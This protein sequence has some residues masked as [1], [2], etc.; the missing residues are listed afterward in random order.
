MDEFPTLEEALNIAQSTNELNEETYIEENKESNENSIFNELPISFANTVKLSEIDNK[1]KLIP[2]AMDEGR[3][4]VILEDDMVIEGRIRAIASSLGRPLIRD[5]TTFKMCHDGTGRVGYARVL[6]EFNAVKLETSYLSSWQV[7]GHVD[8]RCSKQNNGVHVVGNKEQGNMDNGPFINDFNTAKES[9]K[10][11]VKTNKNREKRDSQ[12]NNGIMNKGHNKA[13]VRPSDTPVC[14]LC[15]CEE[16]GNILSYGTC[17]NCNSGTGNSFTYDTI[18][19]SFAEI[20]VIP[21]PPPQGHFNIY[22]CQIC[23]SNSHYGYECSQR[24]PLV[25]EPEPC[26]IQNFSENDYSHDLPGVN[27]LIDHH[28]CYKCGNSL[29][30]FFCHHCACEFCGNDAHVGYNC[31]AQIT[32]AQNKLM[33][34]LTSMCAMVGQLIQ[35]KQE[36]KQIEEEQAANDR[37]WKI[38][39]CCDDDD[40]YNSAITPN[41]PVDSLSMGDEHLNNIPATKS[42]KFIKSSVENLVPN[43]SESEGKNGCDVPACFTTFLN[44]LFDADYEFDSSDDQLLYDEDVSEK[45][46]SNPLFDEE[47]ISM[48]IY[49]HHF[50]VESDLIES[51]LNRDSSI[52]SSSKIDSL[53][54]EFAGELILLKSIPP[55]IDETDCDPEEDIRLIERLLYDNS[56]PRPPEEFVSENSNVDIESFSPSSI[57][58]EDSDSF[59]EEI[60]LTFTPDDPMLPGI[61]EDDDSERDIL[62]C[63]EL[64][65]N[66]SLS[67]PVIESYHFDILSFSHPPT[68]PPDGNTEILNIKMMGDNSEQ[69]VHMPRLMI[70]LVPNQEQSPDL[71]SHRRLEFFSFLLNALM[72]IHGKNIP[73]LDVPL[74]H[75]Y[76]LD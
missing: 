41:E 53:L 31:P 70:T 50:N 68:K 46:F 30:D 38:P 66:Y 6:A 37:Y 61:E 21:N 65:S 23:E 14:Y 39:A 10:N 24:V 60:D 56:S 3:E 69:K 32:I 55:R 42:D 19:E 47:I 9:N 43:P 4:V 74:F 44:I 71:L 5:K 76:P 28:R 13:K 72:M 33:E 75:F 26:Y 29:N 7:F 15:T 73:I 62:I 2:T 34:Q 67:L 25:Y 48:K 8:G 57:P 58:V 20:Q 63:E 22:L 17:L 1:M 18:P 16:C 45:I 36:E 64:P 35:K 11:N 49:P 40:D 51:M 12:R 27:P 54:D 59:M 52:I